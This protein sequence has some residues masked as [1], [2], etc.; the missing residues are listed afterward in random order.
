MKKISL[1]FIIGA[2]MAYTMPTGKIRPGVVLYKLKKS[3]TENELKSLN[4][5]L[6]SHVLQEEK[7]DGINLHIA[8]LNSKGREKAVSQLMRETGAVKFAEPDL[9][10]SPTNIPNDPGFPDQWHHT[11]IHSAGA[12]ERLT[13]PE[14]LEAVKVCVLDTGVD[15]DHP[16]L[17][18]NLLPGYNA[19]HLRSVEDFHGHGTATAGVIGAVGNNGQGISGVL[20]DVNILP[21]QIN[22]DTDD[23]SAYIS[24]M[25]KGIKWCADQGAKVANLSYEGAS[26]STIDDAATYLREHG[27]LLF[28][29]AGN[30]GTF[31]DTTAY[32][33]WS[34]FLIVGATAQTDI[35]S[36]FSN[37]GPFVDLVAPGERILST[38]LDGKYL[39]RNGT[40][41]SSPMAAGVGAMIFGLNPGFT[42][43]EVENILLGSTVDLGDIG[44]DDLYGRGRLDAQKAVEMALEYRDTAYQSPV[45]VAAISYFNGYA[46]RVVGF[47]GSASTDD[48][49]I[50]SYQWD[51]GDGSSSEGM[52]VEHTYENPGRYF[53]TLTVRDDQ[54]LSASSEALKIEVERDPSVLYA[55]SLLSIDMNGNSITLRWQDN[56]ENE[57]GFV[58][59]RAK[60]EKGKYLFAPVGETASNSDVFTDTIQEK[61][62]YRYRVR[63][64][65][66]TGSSAYSNEVQVSVLKKEISAQ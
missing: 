42:P 27:G 29:S 33:D 6:K 28:M 25:A 53:A 1:L 13:S 19:N 20:W 46:P 12:W 57:D 22:N 14:D 39:Y 7:V 16:D 62:T 18:G 49:T 40:S 60:R 58:I 4:A 65:H 15:Q 38:S 32:P 64:F 8:Q 44:E 10:V 41:F 52:V 63:A 5:L 26:A 35:K 61:G 30:A 37:Y 24:T 23:S 31:Y 17:V 21:V 51:F 56:S 66:E 43:D 9:L 47:D 54:G 45:P 50:V 11:T 3:A 2:T 36:G 59:E 34:S 48:G 55:P